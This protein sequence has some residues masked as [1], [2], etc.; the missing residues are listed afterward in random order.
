MII[1]INNILLNEWNKK[2]IIVND[3][4][5][6]K[7]HNKTNKLY[8]YSVNKKLN[9]INTTINI[10]MAGGALA[11]GDLSGLEDIIKL[12][13]EFSYYIGMGY[14]LWGCIEYSMDIPSGATKM[15][16]AITGFIGVYIIPIIFKAIKNALS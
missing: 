15:K 2:V 3:I 8:S 1:K 14:C 6:N 10:I 5:H 12:L 16:R 11:S 13:Q 4:K 9:K 7:Q